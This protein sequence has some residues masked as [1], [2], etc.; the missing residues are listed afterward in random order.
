MWFALHFVEVAKKLP[1][2]GHL[3]KRRK[4]NEIVIITFSKL[5]RNFA[6]FE[7]I[8]CEKVILSDDECINSLILKLY[9]KPHQASVLRCTKSN[10]TCSCP[11]RGQ[12][13]PLMTLMTSHAF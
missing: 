4:K 9:L 10:S 6:V 7:G 2:C 11:Y 5:L 1:F 13:K 12:H 3:V 8:R